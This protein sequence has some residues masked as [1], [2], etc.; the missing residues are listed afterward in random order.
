MVVKVWVG[1]YFSR[2]NCMRTD[3]GGGGAGNASWARGMPLGADV[4]SEFVAVAGC[5]GEA[6]RFISLFTPICGLK[7]DIPAFDIC[8]EWWEEASA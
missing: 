8:C 2:L 1:G 5:C 3:G 7:E 4:C 6:G